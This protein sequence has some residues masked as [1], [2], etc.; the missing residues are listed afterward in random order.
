MGEPSLTAFDGD[1]GVRP[2]FHAYVAYA[3]AWEP[4]ADDGLERFD[5]ARP[6]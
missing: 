2:S 3:A 5:E 6:G 1:P 4:I